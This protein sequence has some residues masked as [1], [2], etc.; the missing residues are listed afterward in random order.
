MLKIF[1]DWC[2]SNKVH[3][4]RNT[5]LFFMEVDLIVKPGYITK[6][7]IY[8]DLIENEKITP[9]Y[10]IG[11]DRFALSYGSLMVIPIEVVDELKN[12]TIYDIFNKFKILM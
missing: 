8:V 7:G 6:N 4:S 3:I 2:D 12:I 10:L 11:C 5:E 1:L 9:N